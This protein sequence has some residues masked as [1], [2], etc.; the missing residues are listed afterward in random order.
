MKLCDTCKWA[1]DT[2]QPEGIALCRFLPPKALARSDGAVTSVWPPV[3]LQVDG[4]H[5]HEDGR[6]R[7]RLVRDLPSVN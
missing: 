1:D 4:C 5:S 6:E 7:I 2:G 3:R